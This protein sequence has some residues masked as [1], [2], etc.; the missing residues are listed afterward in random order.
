MIRLPRITGLWKEA[1]PCWH[2]VIQMQDF[3]APFVAQ[4]LGLVR[5]LEVA[6]QNQDVVWPEFDPRIEPSGPFCSAD[7]WRDNDVR[8]LPAHKCPAFAG[9]S[10]CMDRPPLV[11]PESND[12]PCSGSFADIMISQLDLTRVGKHVDLPH[13][14]CIADCTVVHRGLEAVERTVRFSHCVAFWFPASYQLEMPVCHASSRGFNSVYAAEHVGF[15]SSHS[16]EPVE[17]SSSAGQNAEHAG[18]RS[19]GCPS[20]AMASASSRQDVEHVGFRSHSEAAVCRNTTFDVVPRAGSEGVST[21]AAP[22]VLTSAEFL[23]GT[24]LAHTPP[25]PVVFAPSAAS[26]RAAR[27]A[28][29]R[30]TS[31]D[32]IIGSEE[33]APFARPVVQS[34]AADGIKFWFTFFGVV[35]GHQVL[36]RQLDWSDQQ[37]VCEAIAH[38]S[39]ALARPTGRVIREPL[40]GLFRPQVVLTRMAPAAPFRTVV[41]DLR[42][43]GADIRT[44]DVRLFCNVADFFQGEGALAPFLRRSQLS[45]ETITFSINQLP[46]TQSA[47]FTERTDTFTVH[48]QTPTVAMSVATEANDAAPRS[49]GSDREASAAFS[50]GRTGRWGSGS[51]WDH[52]V[53]RPSRPPTPPMPDVGP[54]NVSNTDRSLQAGMS[55]TVFD[56][57]F[58]CVSGHGRSR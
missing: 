41:F 48:F 49:A 56:R 40:P 22:A 5:E 47:T 31:D 19:P 12:V 27:T 23:P 14:R 11:E 9:A 43:I 51:R 2:S 7:Q 54:E 20:F 4:V 13:Q 3:V 34:A 10:E 16:K 42:H 8:I 57:H 29:N 17:A 52:R 15:R 35:E 21:V 38:A 39:P 6:C 28:S 46:P 36:Q 37:C 33:T 53:F 26:H 25:R 55:F 18:I 45:V 58:I 24:C 32:P 50:A 30:G 44:E 1:T